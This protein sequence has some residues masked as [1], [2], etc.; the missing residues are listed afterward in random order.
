MNELSMVRGLLVCGGASVILF[1]TDEVFF[2]KNR[3]RGL[4]ALHK[5]GRLCHIKN[6]F[7]VSGD[8]PAAAQKHGRFNRKR[9]SEKANSE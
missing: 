4:H 5:V 7:L 9:N 1:L 3:K 2:I 8:P 6:L